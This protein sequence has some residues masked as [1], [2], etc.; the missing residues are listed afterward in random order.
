[1]SYQNLYCRENCNPYDIRNQVF[2]RIV[3]KEQIRI[4]DVKAKLDAVTDFNVGF[5]T[6]VQVRM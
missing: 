4:T 3:G 2:G 5:K 6:T 1:M